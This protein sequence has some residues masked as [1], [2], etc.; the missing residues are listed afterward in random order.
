M[1]E[2]TQKDPRCSWMKKFKKMG[3][4]NKYEI[5]AT[6]G[7]LVQIAAK[8]IINE[9]LE[10]NKQQMAEIMYCVVVLTWFHDY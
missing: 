8:I 5:V 1:E 10:K 4:I 9:E 2:E 3:S 6:S 7:L